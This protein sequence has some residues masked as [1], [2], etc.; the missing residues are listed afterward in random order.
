MYYR[1]VGICQDVRVAPNVVRNFPPEYGQIFFPNDQTHQGLLK[2]VCIVCL[3]FCVYFAV[4]GFQESV[5]ITNKIIILTFRY[6]TS[7]GNV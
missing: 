7:C 6:F 1:P 2:V 5:K 3:V 4:N